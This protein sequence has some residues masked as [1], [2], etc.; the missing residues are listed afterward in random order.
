[1]V[2]RV[3]RVHWIDRRKNEEPLEDGSYPSEIAFEVEN[4]LEKR[5][6]KRLGKGGAPKKG[7]GRRKKKEFP[8]FVPLD[9]DEEESD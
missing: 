3:A 6:A 1:M 9:K 5:F 7:K 2:C 8:E 4:I